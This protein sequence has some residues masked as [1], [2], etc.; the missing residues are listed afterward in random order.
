MVDEIEGGHDV[1]PPAQPKLEHVPLTKL[2]L[3]REA[4]L[5]EQHYANMLLNNSSR[6]PTIGWASDIQSLTPEAAEEFFKIYYGPNNATVAIVGDIN[7]VGGRECIGDPGLKGGRDL[8]MRR[9]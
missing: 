7:R 2:H 4:L 3:L 1:E 5:R 9:E 6:V 8:H